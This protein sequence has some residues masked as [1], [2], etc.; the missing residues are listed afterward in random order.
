MT[1]SPSRVL[2]ERPFGF[3]SPCPPNHL[4]L[5]RFMSA[6]E[7]ARANP[8][9]CARP[10]PLLDQGPAD[11]AAMAS[12]VGRLGWTEAAVTRRATLVSACAPGGYRPPIV[13]DH[14]FPREF[15]P[16]PTAVRDV[17]RVVSGGGSEERWPTAR[18]RRC[19]DYVSSSNP[20]P[21]SNHTTPN[22]QH[23]NLPPNPTPNLPAQQ[24][25]DL[26]V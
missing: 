13:A 23:A 8:P 11:D 6:S 10:L 24:L 9:R 5:R 7:V 22:S 19:A 20:N 18:L 17:D 2:P 26:A 12:R 14:R 1:C 16:G 15:E 21:Q 4:R 3:A 25:R